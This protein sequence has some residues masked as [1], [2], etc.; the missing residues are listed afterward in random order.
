[1]AVKGLCKYLLKARFSDVYKMI[2]IQPTI[3]FVSNAKTISL[4]S[5]QKSLIIYF[6]Q[7]FSFK[8]TLVFA[9]NS[10]SISQIAKVWFRSPN[11][12]LRSSYT[13]A[14][15]IQQLLWIASNVKLN[16]THNTNRKTSK[17][18]PPNQ[19]ICKP[20]LKNLTPWRLLIKKY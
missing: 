8:I 3:A 4:S 17:T 20:Y 14:F 11:I 2:T 6:L 5:K 1:M 12:N 7:Y 9:G 15:A 16:K 18:K 19:N 13:R 10:T